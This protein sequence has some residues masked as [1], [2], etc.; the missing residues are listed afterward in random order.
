MESAIADWLGV[1]DKYYL[2]DFIDSGGSAFKLLLTRGEQGVPSALDEI[3]SLAER[4]GYIYA[5]VSA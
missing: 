2:S 5:G 1:V 3:R 4:R